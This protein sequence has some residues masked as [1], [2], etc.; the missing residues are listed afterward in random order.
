MKN[1]EKILREI[2]K[3]ALQNNLPIIGP[4]KAKILREVVE[5]NKPKTIL[6][7]GCLVGYSAILMAD[8][9]PEEGKVVTIELDETSADIAEE[10]FRKAGLQEKIEIVRGDANDVIPKLDG[11]FDLVFIDAAKEEYFAYL[12][13]AEEKMHSGSVV[14]ADNVKIFE[15]EMRDFLDYVRNSGKYESKTVEALTF[16]GNKILDAM[17]VSVKK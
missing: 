2:E 16:S 14:I 3:F 12:K 8:A 10:N 13:Y 6:E 15:R 9:M 11:T 7:V 17:E 5:K 1:S 4:D